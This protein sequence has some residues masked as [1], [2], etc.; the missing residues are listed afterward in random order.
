MAHMR[1]G[2]AQPRGWTRAETSSYLLE[3]I[4][5]VCGW[6]GRDPHDDLQLAV[7]FALQ[8]A[9]RQLEATG[10]KIPREQLGM[11]LPE[12]DA[13]VR[14]DMATRMVATYSL[15]TI[16]RR[17]EMLATSI[18]R[19]K[20]GQDMSSCMQGSADIVRALLSHRWGALLLVDVAGV[21]DA[22][23]VVYDQLT[24]E[25]PLFSACKAGLRHIAE[26]L[27]AMGV[28][29]LGTQGPRLAPTEHSLP[30]DAPAAIRM[31]RDRMQKVFN[32]SGRASST[33]GR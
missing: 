6:G 32:A 28:P 30:V 15:W 9:R 14:C 19:A 7:D 10:C 31:A 12:D 22:R 13:A 24:H 26:A 27:L 4:G 20:A 17:F 23:V 3:H 29:T 5:K 16:S 21:P 25:S 2:N 1:D 18:Y 11:L 33:E 8:Q